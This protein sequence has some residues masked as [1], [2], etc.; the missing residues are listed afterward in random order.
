MCDLFDH[1]IINTTG[2]LPKI[3]DGNKCLLVG[4]NHYSKLCETSFVKKNN[5]LVVVRFL[6]RKIIYRFNVPKF[7]LI[8]KRNECMIFFNEMCQNYVITHQFT[9]HAWPP[10]KGMAKCLMKTIKHALFVITTSTLQQWDLQPPNPLW[11]SLWHTSQYEIFSFQG[12]YKV[13]SKIDYWHSLNELCEIVDEQ[14][15]V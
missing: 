11:V 13:Y 1:A 14:A 2:S 10:C 4:I 8:N 15:I 12:I 5:A 7:V 3:F 6:E 9:A